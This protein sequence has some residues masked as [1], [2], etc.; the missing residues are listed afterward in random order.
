MLAFLGSLLVSALCLSLVVRLY[1]CFLCSVLVL[2]R[3]GQASSQVVCEIFF[4]FGIVSCQLGAVF[5][6]DLSQR[7]LVHVGSNSS[8]LFLMCRLANQAFSLDAATVQT[9]VCVWKLDFIIV[10]SVQCN[11]WGL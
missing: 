3:C 10:I 6:G 2:L 7:R 1:L 4:I 5:P 8:F 11:T 9:K